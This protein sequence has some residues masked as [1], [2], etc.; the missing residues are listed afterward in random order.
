MNI[1]TETDCE[2]EHAGK[3]CIA[4]LIGSN[5]KRIRLQR[6]LSQ[7]T[8]AEIAGINAKYLGEIERGIKNPTGLVS[9]RI[10]EALAVPICEIL[11][12][13]LCFHKAD[14]GLDKLSPYQKIKEGE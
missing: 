5:I 9:V 7:E 1:Y 12:S 13:R 11:P 10:A 3:K 8:L 14:S 4:L 6:T 2:E